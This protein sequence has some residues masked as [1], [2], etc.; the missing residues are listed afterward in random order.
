MKIAIL[1]S[2][3]AGSVFAGYLRKGGADDITLVDLYK[4]HMD[5]VA[6]DGLIFRN[7]D[8]EFHLDGFKTAYSADNIGVMDIVI[9]MVKATQTDSAMA[10]A[11]PCIGP[12]TVVA[13]LQNG[14]GNDENVKKFV[15]A[16]RIIFGCGN[17]GTELPEP[18][19]C[20]AKPAKGNNMFIGPAQK[21]ALTDRAG[22]YLEKC[23]AAG[24]LEPKY[25]DDVR[26]YV[27]RKATSNSGFN[28]VCAVLRL[29]IR[30]V[31][32]DPCGVELVWR[33]WHEAANVAEALGIPGIWD[34]MQKE[35][36]NV[37]N[38]LG[39]Y[40]PSMAQDMLMHER[41]TEVT[42]LTGAI[43]D[44]GKKVGVPTPTCDVLTL[45]VKAQEAN[46]A[47]QYKKP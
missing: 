5:K 28:T 40:Y 13:T 31:H 9:L 19:V 12:E 37:V 21:S 23:F 14:L 42:C 30:Q 35:M 6:R 8:G 10:A 47:E 15:P 44:Y 3:A 46:Y 11:A 4:A 7:P 22:A 36:L 2:G 20:V 18:G 43:S 33:I 17:M 41:Q 25:F 24:G 38:N 16:D 1:G 27:W 34:Y 45:V 39:D 26:P 29:K 32:D